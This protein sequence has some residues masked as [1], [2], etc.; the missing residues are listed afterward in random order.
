[1]TRAALPPAC[2]AAALTM[3]AALALAT[4]AAAQSPGAAPLTDRPGPALAPTE[5]TQ[6]G[7]RLAD[8]TSFTPPP[9]V[10]TPRRPPARGEAPPGP[11]D[12]AT[13]LADHVDLS[14][15]QVLTASGGV[16]VWFRG[17][18]LIAER[19]IYDGN[20]GTLAIE[21]PIHLT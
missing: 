19:V 17:A 18:R 3:A 1:M 4:P 14:G 8:G 16:V 7:D 11:D 10:I 2:R 21:G 15:N 9:V 13:L 12:A 5:S 20:A 6:A